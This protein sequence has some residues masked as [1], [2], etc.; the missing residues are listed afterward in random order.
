MKTKND[1]VLQLKTAPASEL[2]LSQGGLTQFKKELIRVGD[3]IKDSTQQRFSVVKD[4]LNH[5]VRTF[6]LW[7]ANGNK[8]SIPIGHEKAGD[9]DRNQGWVTALSVEGDSLYGIMELKDP[10]LAL[11]SDVS[12]YVPVE[13]VDGQGIMYKA[14]IT[15][16]ALCTDP[17]IPGLESFEKL[18]LSYGDS[19]MDFMK[20]IY[21][22]LSLSGDKANEDG[23]VDAIAALIPKPEDGP[24]KDLG[25]LASL[26][27]DNRDLKL[28]GLLSAGLIT[29]EL[30]DV[31]EAKYVK[32]EA[33]ALELSQKNKTNSDAFDFLFDVLS[34]NKPVE[35]GEQ[36]GVQSLELANTQTGKASPVETDVK[37]RRVA[38]GLKD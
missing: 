19:N 13:V 21:K 15:H 1:L 3:Y 20:K 7:L 35:L 14:P 27:S 36:T 31:I 12:I 5:W 25:P 26:M 32:P 28:S 23:A 9:A 2:G 11:T 38:A 22:A 24:A 29:P 34:K 4:T 37:K 6:D 10:A 16:I 18:E 17:V 8:V 33:C 30:K